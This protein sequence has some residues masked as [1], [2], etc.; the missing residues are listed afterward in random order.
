M[1][2]VAGGTITQALI[3]T[4][5]QDAT[6]TPYIYIYINGV[7]Y[8]SKLLYLEH[9]EEPYRGSAVIGISNRDN[10][11]DGTVLNGYEIEIGYGYDSSGHSG[12][13]TDKV[14]TPTLTVK[15]TQHISVMGE[16]VMQLYC[17]DMW[18]TA[19]EIRVMAGLNVWKASTSVITGQIVNPTTPNGHQYVVVSFGTTGSS[20]PTWPTD[21]GEYV[22]DGTVVWQEYG[23]CTPYSNSFN[24]THN[25][26]QLLELVVED[27]LGY[28]MTDSHPDDSII[29]D[30]YPVFEI[31]Q[32]PFET[33]A[34]I[35]YRLIW[36][37][38]EYI[39]LKP[40]STW[41]LV[42]PQDSDE[43]DLT[44]YSGQAPYFV[45]YNE[46]KNLLIPNSIIV[47]CNQDPNGEWNT[48]DYPII[49][50]TASDSDEITGYREVIQVFF[51]GSIDNQDDADARAEAI[52]ARL[53]Q[54]TL[55]GRC[56]LHYHECRLELYDKPAIVDSRGY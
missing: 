14:D 42:Y 8:S 3:D 36:M 13:T 10:S 6:K 9:T 22:T 21:T 26:F 18:M 2:S 28:T 46:K 37:T 5:E 19:R 11:Y 1:R 43:V 50:G 39:R 44:F 24:R 55:G 20:E 53:K 16:R 41:E 40:S 51:A 4:M 54:E 56:T 33:A 29:D 52:L 45:E 7:D 31:N 30:F 27:A 49:F 47:L 35:I 23:Y 12:T 32:I 15:S 34:A 17:E 25:V 48:E 38:K